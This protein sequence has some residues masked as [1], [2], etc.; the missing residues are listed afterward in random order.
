MSKYSYYCNNCGF[1]QFSNEKE[2]IKWAHRNH[3]PLV[4]FMNGVEM[5]GPCPMRKSPGDRYRMRPDLYDIL[6]E[7]EER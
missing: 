3:R 2:V 5:P 1:T 7:Y 4:K 6:Y